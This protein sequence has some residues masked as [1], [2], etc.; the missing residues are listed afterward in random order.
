MLESRLKDFM[1][2]IV[3]FFLILNCME[4]FSQQFYDI[5]NPEIGNK[6]CQE[7][8]TLINNKPQEIQY[9]VYR[10]EFDNL[11]FAITRKDWFNLMFKK[12]DDGIALD[13]VVKGRYDCSI[14]KLEN[15]SIILGDL[16]KPIYLRELKTNVLPTNNNEI[17][18]KIG[19]VPE[20]YRDKEIEFNLLF[21]KDKNLCHYNRFYDL[22]VFRWDLLD[23]GLY[24]DTL[25]YSSVKQDT[26]KVKQEQYVLERNILKFEVPFQKNKSEFSISDIKP[27]YD[28]LKLIDFNINKIIIRAYSSVE[29]DKERNIYLQQE[30]SKSIAEAL[31]E[32]Q[33]STSITTEVL[34]T[35]NWV[36]F[37]K[38]ISSTPYSY[39]S[40]LN[41]EEIKIKLMEKKYLRNWNLI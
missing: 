32:L 3:L 2:K 13:I 27:I 36:D 34:A 14:S 30:R 16:Q 17:I 11:F 38:D 35:E 6:K 4:L 31:K 21:L 9:G 33:K 41:K 15:S 28:S 10:D 1:K 7:C 24:F 23:M 37:M 40:K 12:N 20:K 8:L 39:F 22:K 18:I 26:S 25:T 19:V 29:G 5:K